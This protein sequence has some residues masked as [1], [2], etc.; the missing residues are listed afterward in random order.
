M[1][2]TEPKTRTLYIFNQGGMGM[3]K[4]LITLLVALGISGCAYT[5]VQHSDIVLPDGSPG[6]TVTCN[7]SNVNWCYERISK[8]CPNGYT[9]LNGSQTETTVFTGYVFTQNT[10][11]TIFFKCK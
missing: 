6:H 9:L 8:E 5:G 7:A 2:G 4:I 1:E 11:Q 10:Q 3:K